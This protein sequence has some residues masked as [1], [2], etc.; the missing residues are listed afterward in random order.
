M[1][2]FKAT[3]G[4]VTKVLGLTSQVTQLAEQNYYTESEE[5]KVNIPDGYVLLV[6]TEYLPD[7]RQKDEKKIL[8]N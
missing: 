5:V 1:R 6:L 7:V 8:N 3:Y 4:K 2:H